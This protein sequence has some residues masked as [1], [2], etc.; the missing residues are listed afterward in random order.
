MAKFLFYYSN[1]HAKMKKSNDR[2]NVTVAT[3]VKISKKICIE[4]I[5]KKKFSKIRETIRKF[6]KTA[7]V[8]FENEKKNQISNNS[9]TPPPSTCTNLHRLLANL[10]VKRHV[11]SPMKN[12]Y[13]KITKIKKENGSSFLGRAISSKK[14]LPISISSPSPSGALEISS[15]RE[16]L[17]STIQNQNFRNVSQSTHIHTLR[18]SSSWITKKEQRAHLV[19]K[20]KKQKLFQSFLPP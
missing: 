6:F 2:T 18:P 20:N 15:F 7:Q 4:K 3:N 8:T 13:K 12:V 16:L 11:T 9:S 17:P 5:L 19:L 14:M 10:E 1:F